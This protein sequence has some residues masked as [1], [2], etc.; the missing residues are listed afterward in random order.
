MFLSASAANG[1][2]EEHGAVKYFKQLDNA[3]SIAWWKTYMMML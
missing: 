3:A 1:P 2:G